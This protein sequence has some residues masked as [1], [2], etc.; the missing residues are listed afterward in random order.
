MAC[1]YW[2]LPF[3]TWPAAPPSSEGA[4]GLSGALYTHLALDEDSGL[5]SAAVQA[6][7][8]AG[9]VY[10]AEYPDCTV[11]HVVSPDFREGQWSY[12]QGL[13]VLEKCY[14]SVLEAFSRQEQT[15]LL[16]CPIAGGT[17]AGPLGPALPRL[18]VEALSS[19]LER[20]RRLFTHRWSLKKHS[21]EIIEDVAMC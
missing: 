1:S 9:D 11:A 2:P 14:D 19:G 12:Q 18:T 8:A 4:G 3:R 20:A 7:R 10:V 13:A 15:R 16:L 21:A 5:G 17:F 6:L